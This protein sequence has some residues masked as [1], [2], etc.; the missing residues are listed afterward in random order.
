MDPLQVIRRCEVFI[1]LNDGDLQ[2]IADLPS[3]QRYTY[4][5]D[6]FIFHDGEPAKDFYILD[7]GQVSL[8]VELHKKGSK[9]TRCIKVDTL[10]RGDIFGWSALVAPHFRTMSAVCVKPSTI[11]AV[12]GTEL[13]QLFDQNYAVGYEVMKGLVRVIGARWRYLYRT[14]VTKEVPSQ[15]GIR[16]E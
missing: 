10:T 12:N 1:G 16:L 6:Q 2:K 11:L 4:G 5:T 3:W 14:F 7:E 15:R 13:T 9:E 8:V